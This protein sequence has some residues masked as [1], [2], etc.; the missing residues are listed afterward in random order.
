MLIRIAPGYTTAPTVY[1][2]FWSLAAGCGKWINLEIG[3]RTTA[4]GGDII[5]QAKNQLA[6]VVL[7]SASFG[8]WA[9]TAGTW[10]DVVFTWTGTNASN[11][12][13][14]YVDGTLLGQATATGDLTSDWSNLFYTEFNLGTGNLAGTLNAGK[15]DEV[16]IWDEIID[17]TSVE[18]ESG[19]GSLNGAS[20]TSL[21]KAAAY[22]GG[23]ALGGLIY[24][25]PRP[26]C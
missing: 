23:A 6:A 15:V 16:V 11:G 8:A 26:L 20:R 1:Q 14:V 19:T 21:V 17:P 2:G 7:N 9:P 25:G 22:D 18:L 13:S 4:L 10:Y 12:A 3:H 5:C 24:S